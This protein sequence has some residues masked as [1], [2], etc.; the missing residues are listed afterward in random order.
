MRIYATAAIWLVAVYCG[1]STTPKIPKE[2]RERIQVEARV[3]LFS[4]VCEIAEGYYSLGGEFF[5]EWND[6]IEFTVLTPGDGV[7]QFNPSPTYNLF[8]FT[9]LEYFGAYYLEKDHTDG[10]GES[11]M[12]LRMM[13]R[14]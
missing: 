2:D 12:T 4:E 6:C 7:V 5:G 11:S 8:D 9:P 10:F 3:E 1:C 14:S 13:Y